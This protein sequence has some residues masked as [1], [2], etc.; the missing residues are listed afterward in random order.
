MGPV[1]LRFYL[2]PETGEPHI[3]E[4]G[5]DEDEVEEALASAL[6]DFPGRRDSRIAYGQTVAGRHL[7]I[8]YSPDP[9]GQSAFVI[10]AYELHGKDLAAHER[11]QRRRQR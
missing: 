6:E 1:Q 8:V 5:V 3:H 2:D 9:G 4:H 10:T 11:R 7:K